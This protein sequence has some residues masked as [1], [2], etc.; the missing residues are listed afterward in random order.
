MIRIDLGSPLLKML[1]PTMQS[2]QILLVVARRD[3][4]MDEHRFHPNPIQHYA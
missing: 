2:V 3:T 4:A 1:Y